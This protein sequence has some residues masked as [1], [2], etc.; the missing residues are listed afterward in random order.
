MTGLEVCH[1]LYI[2]N[3]KKLS[4]VLG[5]DSHCLESLG[6]NYTWVKMGTPNIEALRLAF[7]I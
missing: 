6:K 4:Y 7:L 1:Q 2:E 5:S 3:K